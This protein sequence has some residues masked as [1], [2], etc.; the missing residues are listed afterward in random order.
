[1]PKGMPP[2]CPARGEPSRQVVGPTLVGSWVR[3]L[4]RRSTHEPTDARICLLV[5]QDA[6]IARK[7]VGRTEQAQHLVSP[8]RSRNPAA[9]WV[10]AD[11]WSNS[12]AQ[13]RNRLACFQG[14]RDW[15][16]TATE[17][18]RQSLPVP[19]ATSAV[20]RLV[21]AAAS[22]LAQLSDGPDEASQFARDRGQRP[23][24][25]R[26]SSRTVGDAM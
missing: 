5:E 8:H 26:C 24:G 3:A 16:A 15:T 4:H 22:L 18:T 7:R 2:G 19:T 11:R 12:T 20:H 25:T 10:H 17:G 9:T 6:Q 23:G 13:P 14:L 21:H 1:V